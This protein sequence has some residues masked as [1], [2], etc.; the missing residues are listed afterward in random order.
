MSPD[1]FMRMYES[2]TAAHDLEA[3]LALIAD[4]AVY[5]FSNQSSH[6]GKDEIRAVLTRNFE[7][8]KAETYEIRD[9]RWLVSTEE[10]AVGLY[11][12]HWSGEIEGKAV[13]GHGRGTSVLRRSGGAW[14]VVHEHL[15][16]GRLDAVLR[17]H[18]G[19]K[20]R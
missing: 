4:E 11:E 18:T 2:A 1:D 15:S 16:A 12:Y 6:F 10:V 7:T 19:S 17:T 3:T 13:S 9:L 5:L 14:R 8:I 20:E